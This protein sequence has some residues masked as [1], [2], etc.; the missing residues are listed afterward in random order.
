METK[1]IALFRA[2]LLSFSFLVRIPIP[3]ASF[4]DEDFKNSTLFFP[5]VGLFLGLLNL[6]IYFLLSPFFSPNIVVLII[7][8]IQYM[9]AN[10]F[11][12]DGFLDFFEA[13]FSQRRKRDEFV[14]IMKDPRI[15]SIALF[16]GVFYLLAKFF[17]IKDILSQL[18]ISILYVYPIAGRVSQVVVMAFLSPSENKGLGTLF[19]DV[20]LKYLPFVFFLG[21]SFVYFT[22]GKVVVSFLFVPFVTF[23]LVGIPAYK[24]LGGFTGDV[25][26]ASNEVG[27]ILFLC[28]FQI[29]L[30]VV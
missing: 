13:L 17:F 5:I 10:L 15:G 20:S 7:L 27:E 19:R 28:C 25:V 6:F 21:L 18:Y 22:G 30:H 12:F 8:F 3:Y 1:I 9:V 4:K 14:K 26:G 24:R 16:L 23:L 11:H 2:F 29:L